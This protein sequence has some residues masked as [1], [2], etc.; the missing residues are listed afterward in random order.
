MRTRSISAV[1]VIVAGL[2]PTL[3]GGPVFAALMGVLTVVGW[4]EFSALCEKLPFAPRMPQSGWVAVLAL[5]AAG[6]FQWPLPVEGAI[7]GL[8]FAAPL[9]A[10]FRDPANPGAISGWALAVTGSIY[11]G[12]PALAATYLRGLPGPVSA[13]W[14]ADLSDRLSIAWP[15][16]PA[17]LGWTLL[18]ILVTWIADT[19]AY[20]VGRSMGRNKLAPHLSP[21]KTIEGAIGG[22]VGAALVSLAC[23]TLFGLPGGPIA[24]IVSGL[25]LGIAGQI[26]DLSESLLKRQAGIK[27]SGDLIPGHGGILDR[28][29]A[30]LFAFPVGWFLATAISALTA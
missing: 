18:V 7:L 28:I 10:Q 13:P 19:A 3:L 16:T 11:L 25:L 8:A 14:L 26:G 27:D 15:S 5:L 17:G 20:L 24:A 30:L 9:V 23:F 1:G 21:N 6:Y 12:L 4:R 2:L 22:L 29:D